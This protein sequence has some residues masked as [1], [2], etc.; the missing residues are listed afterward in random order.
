VRVKVLVVLLVALLLA[1]G[2][3]GAQDQAE[4]AFW[5][6]V[7]DSKNPEEL[8]AYIDGYPNG[9]FVALAKI[10]LKALQGGAAPTAAPAPAPA[11][12]P[13]QPAAP[14]GNNGLT[15]ERTVFAPFEEI[16]LSWSGIKAANGSVGL[17]AP[18]ETKLVQSKSVTFSTQPS[19]SADFPGLI[20]GKYE[21]RIL[22]GSYGSETVVAR[23]P[24][25]VRDPPADA[26]FRPRIAPGKPSFAPMEKITVAWD[27]IRAP[28]GWISLFQE[29]NPKPVD[30]TSATFLYSNRFSGKHEFAGKA[31]GKYEVRILSG[32]YGKEVVIARAPVLVGAPATSGAVPGAAPSS[33]AGPVAATG[34]IVVSGVGKIALTEGPLRSDD[35]ALRERILA[36]SG[37]V[38][39]GDGELFTWRIADQQRVDAIVAAAA[40]A[41]RLRGYNVSDSGGGAFLTFAAVSAVPRVADPRLHLLWSLQANG[42]NVLLC[43]PPR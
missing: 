17:G 9:R 15:V 30:S 32:E 37:G 10:R 39:C 3:A 13:A 14:A 18:G 22:I 19:G 31:E 23:I 27:D 21:A 25:E 24:I 41:L 16:K 11:A 26:K 12:A 33:A 40:Q 34:K 1:G 8:Q 42:L 29:G 4:V 20:T 38:K 6:T 43:R 35:A 7:K 2:P 36:A 5:E 28:N